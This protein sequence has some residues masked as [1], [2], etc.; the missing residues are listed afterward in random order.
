MADD[1]IT[2]PPAPVGPVLDQTE[3][4]Q[5]GGTPQRRYLASRPAPPR[6]VVDDAS[7]LGMPEG[8]I[9][10]PVQ[11]AVAALVL[12][13]EHLRAELALAHHH[14]TW[15]EERGDLHPVLPVY[16][17]RAFIRELGRLLE[18]SY[19]AVVPGS[20]IYL[21]VGGIERLR[22]VHGLAAGE[23]A[24]RQVAETIRQDLRQTDL[25]G[26]LDSAD[27]VVGLAVAED[28]GADEK[29]DAII[30]HVTEQP[31][32]WEGRRFLFTVAAGIAHFREGDTAEGVLMIA[33][34]ARRS[35]PR[36]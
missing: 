31:F 24:L 30:A 22:E 20:L 23:A 17:R 11:E 19:R 10:V 3:H 7:V 12:E 21:H 8:E 16:H 9:P 1:F 15:L 4:Y 5:G 6:S 13:V 14:E 29:A 18:Q 35:H 25:L 33:D 27:F 2:E 36:H 28:G 34:A 26:Y 32:L